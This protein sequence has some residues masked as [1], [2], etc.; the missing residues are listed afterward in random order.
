MGWWEGDQL[1]QVC[2]HAQRRSSCNP[3]VLLSKAQ[4]V[5][6]AVRQAGVAVTPSRPLPSPIACLQEVFAL[7]DADGSGLL[8]VGEV[9][10]AAPTN[11]ATQ[12]AVRAP[13]AGLDRPLRVPLLFSRS[14]PSCPSRPTRLQLQRA[15]RIL[16]VR[17]SRP[18]AELL[19]QEVDADGDGEVRRQRSVPDGP[20]AKLQGAACEPIL[21]QCLTVDRRPCSP[22]MSDQGALHIP[23][24]A[25]AAARASSRCH[26]C[27]ISVPSLCRPPSLLCRSAATSCCNTC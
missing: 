10:P 2:S 19:M 21:L 13:G 24:N 23:R 16:G 6:H 3:P 27:A 12:P 9:R 15:L 5:L 17:L 8:S 4:Q 14:P 1:Q 18:E 7:F 22:L 25:W 26:G 20:P 11:P